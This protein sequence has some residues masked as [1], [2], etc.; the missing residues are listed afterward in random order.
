[1]PVS[2]LA[3]A[4]VTL[5]DEAA[6]LASSKSI[7]PVTPVKIPRVLV[8]IM[9]FAVK[10][11]VEWAVSSCH[12]FIAMYLLSVDRLRPHLVP[13]VD[14]ATITRHSCVCNNNFVAETGLD[15][16]PGSGPTT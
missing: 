7:V 9:C 10:L 2:M 13:V 6:G 14:C 11:T 1:M 12:V 8:I 15:W 16:V 3:A 4:I 5:T